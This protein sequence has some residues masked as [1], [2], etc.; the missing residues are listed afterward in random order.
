MIAC[1]GPVRSLN[2]RRPDSILPLVR[3][4]DVA[5]TVHTRA[6]RR[7]EPGESVLVAGYDL[8]VAHDG[9]YSELGRRSERLVISREHAPRKYH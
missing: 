4:I 5:G 8:G 7:F 2:A 3:G 1:A 6:D 9:G